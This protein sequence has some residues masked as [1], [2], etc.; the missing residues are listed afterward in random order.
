MSIQYV[1]ILRLSVRLA[2]PTQTA[3]HGTLPPLTT[4]V[5]HPR[6]VFNHHSDTLP[7]EDGWRSGAGDA[8][9]AGTPADA[10]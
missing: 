4:I 6:Q 3:C 8:D 5:K 10:P 1:H 7:L 9:A 2:P